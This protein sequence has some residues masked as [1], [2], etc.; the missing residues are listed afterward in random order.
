MTSTAIL[1]SVCQHVCSSRTGL[2]PAPIPLPSTSSHYSCTFFT[3]VGSISSLIR[4]NCHS[5]QKRRGMNRV[6]ILTVKRTSPQIRV[7]SHWLTG[8][9]FYLILP[10][11]VL[12]LPVLQLKDFSFQNLCSTFYKLKTYSN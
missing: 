12:H 8:I 6:D 10:L 5:Q 4:N 11:I 1:L 2:C 7:K 9:S 3:W